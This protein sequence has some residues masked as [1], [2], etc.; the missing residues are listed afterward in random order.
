VTLDDGSLLHWHHGR[1]VACVKSSR[2]KRTG[3][4]AALEAT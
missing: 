4:T 1:L 2:L 3:G